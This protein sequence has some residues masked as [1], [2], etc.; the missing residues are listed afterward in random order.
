MATPLTMPKLGLTMNTGVI[1]R[2]N[3]KEGDA[4]AKGEILMVVATDKLT[5]DV[6]SPV[7]GTL[8]KILVPEGKDVPVGE[9]LAYLGQAGETVP[10]SAATEAAGTVPAQAP[11]AA[12]A[13]KP[14]SRGTVLPAG[15]RA[16]PLARKT[17]REE[18]IDLS[19]VTGSGPEGRIVRKDVEA[20]PPL[21]NP[22]R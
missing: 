11:A 20:L 17:A 15:L 5:F 13:E 19:A 12:S 18:G 6:E 16:T 1:S 21:P 14:S 2:W 8:L 9:L 10:G 3:K 4:V 22:G 7:E